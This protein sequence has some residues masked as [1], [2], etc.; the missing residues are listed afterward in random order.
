M[1]VIFQRYT[2][3]RREVTIEVYDGVIVAA[4][5]MIGEPYSKRKKSSDFHDLS[6]GCPNWDF[7]AKMLIELKAVDN[8]CFCEI[9]GQLDKT[10]A[11]HKLLR[12][13]MESKIFEL[14]KEITKLEAILKND[15]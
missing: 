9:C 4:Y 15:L 6:N 7:V 14:K 10:S 2:S 3:K 5:T 12:E 13:A 11:E 8:K 1:K